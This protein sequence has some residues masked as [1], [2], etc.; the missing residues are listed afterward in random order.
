VNEL[1]E[2]EMSEFLAWYD[3]QKSEEPFDNRGVLEK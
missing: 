2:E 3:N 1:V